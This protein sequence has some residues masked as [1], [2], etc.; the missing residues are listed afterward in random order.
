MPYQAV[1]TVLRLAIR[2][3]AIA[4]ARPAFLVWRWIRIGGSTHLR[5]ISQTGIG[6]W[7]HLSLAAGALCYA[8]YRVLRRAGQIWSQEY[9]DYGLRFYARR[10]ARHYAFMGHQDLHGLDQAKRLEMFEKAGPSRVM[11]FADAHPDILNFRDGDSFLDAGCGRGPEIKGLVARYP[12]SPILGLDISAEA[13]A[14]V[15]AGTAGRATVTTRQ[16][17]LTDPQ[18]LSS[19]P[20]GSYD[21][22]VLSHVIPYLMG[23]GLAETDRARQTVIDHLVRIARRTVVILTDRIERRPLA[24][25]EPVLVDAAFVRDDLPAYLDRHLNQ[26]ERCILYTDVTHAALV[27][28]KHR[29]DDAAFD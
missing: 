4:T 12:S 27:L 19:I 14:V 29:L 26:G 20:D 6:P 17:S 25:I 24:T 5:T 23:E 13:L 11:P 10:L 9:T 15:T 7:Q 28:R 22:V 3:L 16:M 18:G 1:E 2:P 21:H 8:V